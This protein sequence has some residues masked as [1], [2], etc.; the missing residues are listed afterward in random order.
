MAGY[1]TQD[2]RAGGVMYSDASF[3]EITG[4]HRVASQLGALQAD[5]PAV[6]VEFLPCIDQHAGQ[7]TLPEPLSLFIQHIGVWVQ[8][9]QIHQQKYV[10]YK[11]ATYTSISS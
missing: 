11:V 10:E 7:P 3:K 1:R 8:T 2:E 6:R 5:L 4:N 9:S